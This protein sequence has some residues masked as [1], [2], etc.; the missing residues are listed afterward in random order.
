M[1]QNSCSSACRKTAATF[2]GLAFYFL[3][4][5]VRT[6]RLYGGA[7]KQR[8]RDSQGVGR[9]RIADLAAA[10]R[11][12]YC[13]GFD[14]LCDCLA[15]RLVFFAALLQDYDYRISIGPWVFIAAAM[16]L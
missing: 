6:C 7:A 3:P 2:A 8:D 1:P 5:P 14:Q 12:F 9:F 10:D 13:I 4:R 15:C 16:R 11:G